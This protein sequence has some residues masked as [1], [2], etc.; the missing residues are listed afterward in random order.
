MCE[1]Q[2]Q[3]RYALPAGPGVRGD[4]APALWSLGV[5]PGEGQG[6]APAPGLAS[7]LRRMGWGW[8]VC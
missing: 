5:G 2:T 7:R 3:G 6:G 8:G 4:G 1:G